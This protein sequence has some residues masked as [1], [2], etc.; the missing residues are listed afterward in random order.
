MRL[1]IPL[2]LVSLTACDDYTMERP[3]AD[4]EPPC[5]PGFVED[6]GACLFDEVAVADLM[7][8]LADG[9]LEKV[10]DAPFLQV[11]GPPLERNVW[12][13]PIP[14]EGTD[15]TAADLYRLVVPDRH[16][17]LPAAFPVGTL[18][19]H[20]TVDR[21]EGHTVQVK[22]DEDYDDGAGR[23]WWTGKFYD[24]GEPDLNDC[25]PCI[26][27]HNHEAQPETEGLIG[28]PDIAL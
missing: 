7:R 16:E 6:D 27:C 11:M 2:L 26:A 25:T 23:S 15:L 9:R 5:S 13:T 3:A 12:V 19:V 14:V 28:V 17:P 10:N 22:L 18:I 24:D 8:T 4:N 21:S 1:F 20:E